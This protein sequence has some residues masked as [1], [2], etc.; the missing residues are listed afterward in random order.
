[1]SSQLLRVSRRGSRAQTL[2]GIT[3]LPAVDISTMFAC[4]MIGGVVNFSYENLTDQR[5]AIL[6]VLTAAAVSVFKY[7]GHYDRR[8]LF[9]QEVG[10][11][12]VVAG[13]GFLLDAALLYLLKVNFSRLWVLTSWTLIVFS[14]PIARRVVKSVMLR[15]GTW[16]EPTVVIGTGSIAREAAEA[17]AHDRYLGYEIIA[18]L[19]PALRADG[20][21]SIELEGRKIPV[22]PMNGAE[23]DTLSRFGSPHVVVA[24]DAEEVADNENLIERLCLATRSLDVISPL[25]GLP[26]NNTRLAHFFSREVLALRIHNN[27]ARP[28]ARYLKRLF[29]LAAA[30]AILVLVA[31][32]MAVIALLLRLEGGPVLF[33]H[34]R[35]GRE[36]R[37]F[38]CYKFRSMVPNAKE[39]LERLLAEDPEARAEW[40]R[41]QKLRNDPRIT[42]LGHVLRKLSLDELPQLFNVLKGDMSLVG[43]RPVVSEELERYG[44]AKVYYLMVRPGL[45]GLWQ[46]SGRNDVDYDQRVALDTWYVRNW[47]LWNDIVILFKTLV[48]VPSRAGAY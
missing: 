9:W 26:I 36:G 43:P 30:S 42:R 5:L 31:P 21:R 33:A 25:R 1:M 39:V 45:T 15:H 2:R 10:D 6:L 48:V 3:V 29:D 12:V 16:R 18:F 14:V 35:V 28:W 17:Y 44:D 23:R 27:L 32:L 41:D 46:I 47:T 4:F 22:L 20:E 37:L 7:L 13:I 8:R 34:Q 24:L 11:I 40:E 38:P 19:D